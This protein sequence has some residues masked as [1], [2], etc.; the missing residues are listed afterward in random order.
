MEILFWWLSFDADHTIA[1]ASA[2]PT[3]NISVQSLFV[4]ECHVNLQSGVCDSWLN[5]CR[6]PRPDTAELCF[7]KKVHL[8]VIKVTAPENTSAGHWL[9][10]EGE[11][12]ITKAKRRNKSAQQPSR[13]LDLREIPLRCRSARLNLPRAYGTYFWTR[14]P[15]VYYLHSF[16]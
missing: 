15:P 6:S 11:I 8:C 10:R 14:C 2:P 7:S 1:Q 3:I 4:R 13:N 16:K 12:S 9:R 5:S